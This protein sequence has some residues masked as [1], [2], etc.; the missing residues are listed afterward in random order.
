MDKTNPSKLDV[1]ELSKILKNMSKIYLQ[2]G[3]GNRFNEY[4]EYIRLHGLES[5]H[6]LRP[7]LP[8]IHRQAA[9]SG[10][11]DI[12]CQLSL[13]H[14]VWGCNRLSEEL[15]KQNIKISA[16]AVYNVLVKY[17][18]G[19]KKERLVKL[20]EKSSGDPEQL[21]AEQMLALEKFDP[22]FKERQ[23]RGKRPGEV[24]GQ[25]TIF[26]G[27]HENMEEVYLQA[28]VDSYSN[29]AFGFIHLGKNPDSAVAV[30]HNEVLPFFKKLNLPVLTI[31]TD[32]GREY[33]GR[34]GHHYELYLQL[35]DILHMKT[36]TKQCS[37]LIIKHFKKIVGDDFIKQAGIESGKNI[38]DI[39]KVQTQFEKWLFYY[40]NQRSFQGFANNGQPPIKLITQ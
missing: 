14:P 31:L 29:Y 6:D 7:A 2:P 9:R 11:F 22:S 5:I 35:N 17:Q 23:I 27:F 30:I 20:K 16:S 38:G 26:I 18:L 39:T 32:N 28:A 34:E 4:K 36:K 13:E 10:I 24:L 25:D 12:V 1:A 19:T 37:N 15:A 21:S 33:C 3:P 8:K 40:N